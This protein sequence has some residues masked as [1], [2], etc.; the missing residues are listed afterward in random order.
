MIWK[1]ILGL[2]NDWYKLFAAYKKEEL[3]LPSVV[4]KSVEVDKLVTY[5]EH[6]YFNVTNHLH[7]TEYESEFIFYKWISQWKFKGFFFFNNDGIVSGKAVVDEVSVLVQR[8]QL[9]HKAFTV[10]V[11]VKSE[12]AKTVVVKFFLAPKYDSKGYEIP[13]HQNTENFFMLDQF[14][15]DCEYHDKFQ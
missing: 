1:R 5:F 3:T 2:F 14:L 6:A 15:Y 9:N 8:P 12:V 4:I 11:N 10:R 7:M 13:L